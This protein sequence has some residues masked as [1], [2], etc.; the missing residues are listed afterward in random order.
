MQ[1]T[2]KCFGGRREVRSVGVRDV[3][4]D[5]IFVEECSPVCVRV[6]VQL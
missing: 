6:V 4:T 3:S 1:R 2:R 5:P